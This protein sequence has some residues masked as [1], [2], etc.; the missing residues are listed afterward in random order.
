MLTLPA[1]NLNTETA[2][3]SPRALRLVQLRPL[4]SDQVQPPQP[5]RALRLV[6]LHPL[7]S[8]QVQPHN[9]I[10]HSRNYYHVN[11]TS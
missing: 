6:Q 5:H 9:P 11:A 2:V 4:I 10:K 7:L 3:L 8:G 1:A